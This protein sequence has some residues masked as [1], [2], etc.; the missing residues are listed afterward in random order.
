[1]D[2]FEQVIGYED[3]KAELRRI[4]D[5]VRNPEKYRRLGV[6]ISRGTMLYGKPGVGKSLLAD[7]FIASTGRK[8]Y[9]IRKNK[10]NGDFVDHISKV[11]EKAVENAPSIVFLD[12]LDKFSET[13]YRNSDAEEYVAIQSEL[14]GIKDKGN[15]VYCIATC[16]DIDNLPVSLIRAGRFDNRIEVCAPKDL[17]VAA[18]II[19]YYLKDKNVSDEINAADIARLTEGNTC[20]ELETVI[21]E[22]G[23]YAGYEGK[24][25]IEQEDII[26]ACLRVIFDAPESIG[27]STKSADMRM[28]ATHEAG[29]VVVAE[30]LRPG[31]VNV[32][33]I[34]R[35]TGDVG[36]VTSVSNP[37]H[38]ETSFEIKEEYI[39][40]KLGGRAAVDVVYG[41]PDIASE[42]DLEEAYKEMNFYIGQ[43]HLYGFDT[44]IDF[45]GS[46]YWRSALNHRMTCEM[47]RLYRQVKK[48]LTDNRPFLDAVVDALL[49][50]QTLTFKDIALI[51]EQVGISGMNKTC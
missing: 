33:S 2:P 11:F 16:N 23:I 43:L 27:P 49:E 46:E 3:I 24:D 7:C 34:K 29:H 42:S 45:D 6:N 22:A 4:S 20:A 9:L 38:Y 25:R 48:I 19:A 18:E 47:E 39:M 5:V 10:A 32:T 41:V 26:K 17:S 36:G 28:M 15:D 1:M 31:I 37:D 12:D 51:R 40:R 21:N 44:H 30:V 13:S 8:R 14:D 50:K 35:H